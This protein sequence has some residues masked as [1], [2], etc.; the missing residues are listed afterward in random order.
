MRG[1]VKRRTC[2]EMRE[3]VCGKEECIGGV[4]LVGEGGA[5]ERATTRMKLCYSVNEFQ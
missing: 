2:E 1:K 4:R 3:I 5:V